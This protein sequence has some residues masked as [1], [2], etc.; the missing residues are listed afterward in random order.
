MNKSI[1]LIDGN[2]LLFKSFYASYFRLKKGEERTDD[3]EPINAIRLFAFMIINLRLMYKDSLILVAFDAKGVKT[4]RHEYDFYKAKRKK[5]PDE[6]Y[7]QIPIAKEFLDLFGIKWI[8]DDE[9]LKNEADDIIGIYAEAAKKQN[10]FVDIVTSDYDLLQLV[11]ENV[12]VHLSKVGVTNMDD[13]TNENFYEKFNGLSPIQIPDL[14]GLMGDSSDNLSGIH[15]IGEKT[16]IDLLNKYY[17]IER[18]FDNVEELKGKTKEKILNG[19][20]RGLKSKELAKIKLKGEIKPEFNS[21]LPKKPNSELK[22]WLENKK[23]FNVIK[24]L[25]L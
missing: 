14:K 20:K 7:A 10:Y 1:L 21:L 2:S 17:S 15:G 16:A 5:Q 22:K 9:F 11:D 24:K 25:N 19:K 12:S 3:N 8:E 23:L 18:I 6:L 13:Y 4:F